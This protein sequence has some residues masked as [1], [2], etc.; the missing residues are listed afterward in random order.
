MV[1]K[2]GDAVKAIVSPIVR[3]SPKTRKMTMAWMSK[4]LTVFTLYYLEL[5]NCFA[6]LHFTDIVIT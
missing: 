4:P 6:G 3:V 2:F 1:G 5:N